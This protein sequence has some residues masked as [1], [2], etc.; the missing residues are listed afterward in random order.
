MLSSPVA[1]GIR[2]GS[3][4]TSGSGQMVRCPGIV[5]CPFRCAWLPSSPTFNQHPPPASSRGVQQHCATQLNHFF[6]SSV[7]FA[8]PA[9]APGQVHIVIHPGNNYCVHIN[10]VAEQTK[11]V[12]RLPS[13]DGITMPSKVNGKWMVY[14]LFSCLL[15]L[16]KRL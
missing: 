7:C 8:F 6:P 4:S 9:A 12:Y 1:F 13:M 10:K 5:S 3:L 2:G 16:W 15:K 14:K 11:G